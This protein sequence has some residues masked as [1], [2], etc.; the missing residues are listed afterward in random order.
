MHGVLAWAV[1]PAR[2][3]RDDVAR[4]VDG[5]MLYESGKASEAW[6]ADAAFPR[7]AERVRDM[8]VALERDGFVSFG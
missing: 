4:A 1:D 6:E 2:T 8:L 3:G 7:V 5:L